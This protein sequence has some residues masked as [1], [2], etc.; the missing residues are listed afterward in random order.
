MSDISVEV[1]FLK[2]LKYFSEMDNNQLSL[3]L[4]NMELK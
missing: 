2:S 4:Q 1:K 3:L